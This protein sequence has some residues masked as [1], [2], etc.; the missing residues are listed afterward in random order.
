MNAF[1]NVHSLV[2]KRVLPRMF[3]VYLFL[4]ALLVGGAMNATAQTLKTISDAVDSVPINFITGN[5]QEMRASES[6]ARFSCIMEKVAYPYTVKE[7]SWRRARQ[8]MSSGRYDGIF[9]SIDLSSKKDGILSAPIYLEEWHWYWLKGTEFTAPLFTSQ[10]IGVIAGSL[11]AIWLKNLGIE[12]TINANTTAHLIKLLQSKRIQVFLLSENEYQQLEKTHTELI[13]KLNKK[14]YRYVPVGIVF[15][16]EF[17][18]AHADFID[19][20]N[21]RVHEC[22]VTRFQVSSEKREKVINLLSVHFDR[23]KRFPLLEQDLRKSNERYAA[24]TPEEL[25]NLEAAWRDAFNNGRDQMALAGLH[26]EMSERLNQAKVNSQGMINNI[27]ITNAMG[28]VFAAS[29]PLARFDYMEDSGFLQTIELADGEYHVGE[30]LF[31]RSVRRTQLYV[32]I[33]MRSSETN[34]LLGVMSFGV[35]VENTLND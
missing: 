1:F 33:P 24:M 8:E 11:Q 26:P 14:H 27:V 22:Y 16:K 29:G 25:D 23:W 21:E 15:N 5:F 32:H 3:F 10:K 6:Y 19:E 35:D 34:E 20:F 7:S 2:V 30:V 17:G 12:H 18:E 4:S 28:K 13:N 9:P 31:S